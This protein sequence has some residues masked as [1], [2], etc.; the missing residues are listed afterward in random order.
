MEAS[1]EPMPQ[2]IAQGNFSPAISDP[3]DG[4][5]NITRPSYHLAATRARS[6]RQDLQASLARSDLAAR[7]FRN[8]IS[9]GVRARHSR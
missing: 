9:A 5:E 3:A 4:T 1:P 2:E 6:G 7:G 8:G